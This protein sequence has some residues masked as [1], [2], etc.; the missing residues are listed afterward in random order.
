MKKILCIFV[1]AVSVQ[2]MYA[3]SKME[4]EI[5]ELSLRFVMPE[6]NDP[7]GLIFVNLG[8][9]FHREIVPK[10]ISPGLYIDAGIGPDW[11]ELFS[12]SDGKEDKRDKEFYQL[13]INLGFRLYN[14]FDLGIASIKPFVGYNL[15]LGQLDNRAPWAIHN[16]VIGVSLAIKIIGIEYCYYIPTYFSNNVPFHHLA[17]KLQ[18]KGDDL[19]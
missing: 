6:E 2:N 10:L 7:Q 9:G 15:I 18:I 5:L 3:E 12:D 17:I 4:L 13:G 19:L 8:A 16:P 14:F 11:L 1:L